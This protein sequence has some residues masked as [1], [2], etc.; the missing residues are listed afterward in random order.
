MSWKDDNFCGTDFETSGTLPEY[1]L[2]AWRIPKGDTWATSLVWMYASG[3][4]LVQKGG[5]FPSVDMMREFLEWARDEKR[6]IVGWNVLFDIS[7]FIGHGLVDLV[8]ECRWLDAMHLYR[9][10][11]IEPEYDET[12][13]NKKA[14]RLKVAVAEFLPQHAGYE[15]DIDYHSTNPAELKKLHDYNVLDVAFTLKIAKFLYNE[16]TPKQRRCAMMEAHCLP[17]V[18]QANYE[19]IMID[20][21]AANNLGA[22]LLA[23]S[24]KMLKKLAP[25]GVTEKIVRSPVQL[26]KLMFDDWKLPVL[27]ENKSKK[28]GNVTRS[29]DKEVLHELAFVDPRAKDLR[30]YRESLGNKTKF[31]DT[32]LAAV[33]YN[34]DGRARPQG[35]VFGT[36]SGRMT[37]SSKQGKNKDE[38]QTGWAIHQEKR[39]GEFRRLAIAPPG[40]TIMEFDASGQ[41]F[42][43]MA[44][45]SNDP[46]MLQLCMPGE[47]PHSFMGSRISGVAYRALIAAVKAAEKEAKA[48]RQ[49]GKVGNLSLQYRTSAKKLRVVARVDYNIPMD[50]DTAKRIRSVYLNTYKFVPEYWASQIEQ[51]AAKGYAETFA[52]RRVIVQGD[53]SGTN[54]WSMASTAINYPIQ[55]T[56]ADQKYLAMAM[57]REYVHEVGGRLMLDLHDGIYL[58]I[59]DEI[60]REVAYTVKDILDNLPYESA[61]GLKLPIPMTWDLKYGKSWGDLIEYEFT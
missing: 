23:T 52:G 61:W 16:L 35:I 39:G 9:H 10:Y 29:T 33:E 49:L 15:V 57:I 5:L 53:W 3:G 4:K 32:P 12:G 44:V 37:Y 58:L 2:Q 43:W 47:D 21:I 46:V 18:A 28:T 48:H 41:E 17:L 19:G 30:T 45:A 24:N 31:V 20:T 6:I 55:G 14:Y 40:Y 60:V 36:Y 1:A 26:S 56:G 38:R 27:K 42:R 59:P 54:G 11:F 13:R 22:E 34:G 25:H 50:L 8:F 51:V 7:V